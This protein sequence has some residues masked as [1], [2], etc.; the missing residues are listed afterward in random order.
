MNKKG[1][2]LSINMLVVIIISLVVLGGGVGL[3]FKFM[4]QA[5]ELQKDLDSRT[6]EELRRLLIDQGKQV[7]ISLR[8]TTV[9][10]GDNFIF[11]IGI[12]NTG[13]V[14]EQ[15]NMEVELSK[16]TDE[17]QQDIT[18]IIDASGWYLYNNRPFLI[19]ENE[20]FSGSLLVS[21]PKDATPGQYIFKA[22][23]YQ[24]DGQ[25]YGNTQNM[26]VKVI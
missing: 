5:D 18:T 23:V 4:G 11:G 2:E 19:R 13:G 7:A 15:F 21:P 25:Q 1:M 17:Q 24:E 8:T 14:G 3:L 26:V 9:Q 16:A 12:L 20:H 6:K 10:R 22:R